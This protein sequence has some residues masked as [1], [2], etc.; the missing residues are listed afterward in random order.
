MEVKDLQGIVLILVL[1]GMILGVGLLVLD[2]FRTA[3]PDVDVYN[4]SVTKNTAVNSTL[5]TSDILTMVVHSKINGTIITAGNYTRTDSEIHWFEVGYN[6]TAFW[7]IG[8]YS[9][10]DSKAGLALSSTV[11]ALAPIA[12]TWM[13]LIVTIA[14]LA[15]I[16]GLV[17]RSFRAR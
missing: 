2:S 13:S 9:N 11:T 6:T 10:Y 16:L 8:T 3:V 15:I 14:I 4:E 1:V 12:S 7:A 17:I 5:T